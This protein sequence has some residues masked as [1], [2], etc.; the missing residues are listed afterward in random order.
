MSHILTYSELFVLS[1][2]IYNRV[3]YRTLTYLEP[4]KACRICKMTR[5]IQSPGIVH[6]TNA[7]I[8]NYIH[9]YWKCKCTLGTNKGFEKNIKIFCFF[10]S[11]LCPIWTFQFV[12]FKPLSYCFEETIGFDVKASFASCLQVL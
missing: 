8:F 4:A 5:Y 6:G 9:R 3:I 11:R 12:I 1:P 7:S 2:C 10:Y